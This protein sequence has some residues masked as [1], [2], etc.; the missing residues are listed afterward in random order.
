M[1]YLSQVDNPPRICLLTGGIGP[2][3]T[4]AY[5]LYKSLW[6]R[7]KER[8]LQYYEMYPG[9]IA[10]VKKIVGALLEKPA[11]LPSGGLLTARRFLQQ[12]LALG[13]SPS[14][15]A[16]IHAKLS[17]AFLT[18]H[19]N[20]EPEFT[21]AFLQG[22]EHDAPFDN[23]PFYF[24]LHESIYGDGPGF[25]PTQWAAH[26]AYEDLVKTP[27]EFDYKLTSTMDSD[28]RPT[29]FFGEMVFPWMADGDY[30]E[31][32]GLG[33]RCL[34]HA[35]AQKDDWGPLYDAHRMRQALGGGSVT[36]A[37]AAVY[38]DDMYVDFDACL[39]LTKRGGPLDKCKLWITNEY[40]HSGLRDNGAEIFSKL[41]SMATGCTKTP[42]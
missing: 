26:R 25:S 29:L 15:F 39:K 8:N 18:D 14:A 31:L 5:D 16:A 35:L 37:A 20:D 40:Q 6:E 36:R 1:T 34:A 33:M 42:S 4:A 13:G 2:M 3:S 12:G 32:S 30:V 10:V 19:D 22:M 28:A 38:V 41:Y 17:T 9:D 21:K 23:H 7:V 27:S 24:L 11:A